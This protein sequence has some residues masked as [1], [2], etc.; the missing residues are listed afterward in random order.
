M[1]L[2]DFLATKPWKSRSFPLPQAIRQFPTMLSVEEQRM[3]AFLAAMTDFSRGALVDLGPFMGGST[4]ALGCGVAMN[5]GQRPP[6]QS[7]DLFSASEGQKEKFLYARGHPK[8]DGLDIYPLF[9]SLTRDYNVV[10]TKADIRKAR[11]TTGPIALLFIDLSKSW[12]INDHLVL[13]FLPHVAQGGLIVQQDYMFYKNPWIASTMFKL[14]DHVAYAG[15]SDFNSV[16]FEVT[17]PLSASALDSCLRR[18]T[19]VAD[20][21]AAFDWTGGFLT[22]CLSQE[23]LAM[24]RGAFDRNPGGDGHDDFTGQ[25]W[26]SILDQARQV[27]S[28]G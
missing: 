8:F 5:Q 11:W 12:A 2:A 1:S 9:Q 7:F 21:H 17:T 3:L 19:S 25:A 20:M 14:R 10:S 26:P 28:S 18:N 23:M 16:L 15:H 22:D 27:R 6:I 24:M 4:S 13:N